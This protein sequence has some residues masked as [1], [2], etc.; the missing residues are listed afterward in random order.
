MGL[1]GL[2]TGVEESIQDLLNVSYI[3]DDSSSETSK[4]MQEITTAMMEIAQGANTQTAKANEGQVAVTELD[5]SI[6][7]VISGVEEQTIAVKN[8][9]S[10][11]TSLNNSISSMLNQIENIDNIKI[12]VNVSMEKIELIKKNSAEMVSIIDTI[13]NISEQ[14]NLLAMNASIEAAHAGEYGKGFDVVAEEIRNLSLSTNEAVKNVSQLIDKYESLLEETALSIEESK[15]VID[16]GIRNL[17]SEAEHMS[18]STETYMKE[19]DVVSNIMAKTSESAEIMTINSGKVSNTIKDIVSISAQNS[20]ASEKIS[21]TSIEISKHMELLKK[22]SNYLSS[23]AHILQGSIL[24]FDLGK[25]QE[26]RV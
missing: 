20:T 4:A 5:S 3:L 14:T 12:Q 22:N 13:K 26:N 2:V 16:S 8:S 24:Q 9:E 11:G 15:N 6:Q 18:E 25:V 19:M 7:T 1:R 17:N 21:A 10:A 23:M